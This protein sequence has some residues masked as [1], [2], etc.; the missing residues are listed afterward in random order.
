[1]SATQWSPALDPEE[2]ATIARLEVA[3]S[4]AVSVTFAASTPRRPLA[5]LISV[6]QEMDAADL[7]GDGVVSEE[8]RRAHAHHE[9][10]ARDCGLQK[11]AVA[12]SVTNFAHRCVL[13][14]SRPRQEPAQKKVL[15]V[16]DVQ[17]GYDGGFVRSLPH[18]SPGGLA[19]IQA[20]HD[21]PASYELHSKRQIRTYAKGEMRVR[22]DKVWNQGLDGDAFGRVCSRVVTE[23]RSMQYD[24]IVFTSDYLERSD[25]E[26][27]GVFALDS[28]PW[29]E[30]TKPVALVAYDKFLT[31]SAGGLGTNI[32]R[33]IREQ[34]PEVTNARGSEG[35]EVC[36]VPCLY[37]RKQVDD[38]FDDAIESSARTLHQPW[39]D[40]VDVDDNGLPKP[41]AETLLTK[42]RRLGFG[43]GEADA[44][45]CGVVTNRCVASSLLHAVEHGYRARLLE[46]GCMAATDG[47]HSAGLALIKDKGGASV[48]IIA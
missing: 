39:L 7:D 5:T 29:S 18:E 16:I 45:F 8:E 42:L 47:E 46:G 35:N 22:Y 15:F 30:P 12:I 27:K 44:T 3:L 19:F 17:D 36:G 37:L 23:L 25:G 9:A 48:E 33:R 24:L 11:A 2:E 32:S 41:R 6:L 43:P 34:L 14:P 13:H 10:E 28:T 31:F 21:V 20:S 40:N 26:E 38:A 1:M 4:E